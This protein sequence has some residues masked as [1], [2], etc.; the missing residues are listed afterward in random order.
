MGV[1]RRL[2]TCATKATF[3]FSTRS[4]R[5][6][7]G[8]NPGLSRTGA[9]RGRPGPPSHR[10]RRGR[11]LVRPGRR[12]RRLYRGSQRNRRDPRVKL[13]FPNP[14]WDS[15]G[16]SQDSSRGSNQVSVCPASSNPVS[17]CPA[18]YP[19]RYRAR[20]PARY[21][22][23]YPA[24]SLANRDSFS[25]DSSPVSFS[26]EAGRTRGNRRR[27]ARARPFPSATLVFRR[28]IRARSCAAA[29]RS[30]LNGTRANRASRRVSWGAATTTIRSA[31]SNRDDERRSRR[32]V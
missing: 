23:R 18:R 14:A 21:P 27:R 22:V 1:C 16:R 5:R 3:L 11:P 13:L 29:T 15:R 9:R 17:V 19:A 10:N 20:Y 30:A 32:H 26:R 4:C 31:P 28:R 24:N 25:P 2:R 8:S 6:A 7:R 12:V